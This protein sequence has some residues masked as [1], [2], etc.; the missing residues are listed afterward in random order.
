MLLQGVVNA[1]RHTDLSLAQAFAAATINPAT[2][3]GLRKPPVRPQAGRRANLIVF[4]PDDSGRVTQKD[5][6]AVFIDG[7]RVGA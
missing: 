4:R 3:M 6:E 7:A 5:I 1:W 2:L